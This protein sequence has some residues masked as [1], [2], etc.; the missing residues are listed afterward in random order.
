MI[1]GKSLNRTLLVLALLLACCLA[2]SWADDLP[3]W[4]E[5]MSDADAKAALTESVMRLETTTNELEASLNRENAWKIWSH[6]ATTL[7]DDTMNWATD[8]M[9]L[10]NELLTERREDVTRFATIEISLTDLEAEHRTEI[11]R[12][13]WTGRIEGMVVGAIV[14]AFGALMLR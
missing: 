13:L 14:G 1:C 12:T 9:N 2:S 4:V 10:N 7:A 5:A 3:P 6:D 8:A 11:R